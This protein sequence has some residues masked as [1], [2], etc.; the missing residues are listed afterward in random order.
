MTNKGLLEDEFGGM[1]DSGQGQPFSNS[2]PFHA[3]F[4]VVSFVQM[5]FHAKRHFEIKFVA[6]SRSVRRPLDGRRTAVGRPSVGRRTA[7]GV[8]VRRPSDGRD[9]CC[10]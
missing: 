3:S 9:Y 2:L 6:Q 4:E 10:I 7:V 8:T 5:G 1:P